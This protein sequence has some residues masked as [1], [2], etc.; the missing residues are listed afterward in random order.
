MTNPPVSP[1]A[2]IP[3]IRDDRTLSRRAHAGKPGNPSL[4][5]VMNLE[6]IAPQIARPGVC[7]AGE[8]SA[9]DDLADRTA[10]HSP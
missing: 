9:F 6:A 1:S 2:A 3:D 5:I 4:D 7:V 10:I 8:R